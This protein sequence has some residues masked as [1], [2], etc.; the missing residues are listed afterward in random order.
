MERTSISHKL[1]IWCRFVRRRT[2]GLRRFCISLLS[3]MLMVDRAL[4]AV[5]RLLDSGSPS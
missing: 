1:R 5:M 3:V 2:R 4:E